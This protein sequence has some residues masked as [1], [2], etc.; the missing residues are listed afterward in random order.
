MRNNT[1]RDAWHTWADV[2]PS[3]DP[4]FLGEASIAVNAHPCAIDKAPTGEPRISHEG[5]VSAHSVAS[6]SRKKYD[7][8]FHMVL[9]AYSVTICQV[10]RTEQFTTHLDALHANERRAEWPACLHGLWRGMCLHS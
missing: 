5:F 2:S 3:G 9:A 10:L 8:I 6:V 4:G 1:V 7:L